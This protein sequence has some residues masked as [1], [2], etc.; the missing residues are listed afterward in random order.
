MGA[1]GLADLFDTSLRS[2]AWDSEHTK[3]L[4]LTEHFTCIKDE[5]YRDCC[6]QTT[7]RFMTYC[8]TIHIVTVNFT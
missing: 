5:G 6:S 2:I 8:N 4:R 3:L 1:S 7:R